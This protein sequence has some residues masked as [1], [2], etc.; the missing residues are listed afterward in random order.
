MLNHVGFFFNVIM[1]AMCILQ[2]LAKGGAVA[3]QVAVVFLVA[4]KITHF[5]TVL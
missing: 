2:T 1:H 3:G 4:Q 5:I